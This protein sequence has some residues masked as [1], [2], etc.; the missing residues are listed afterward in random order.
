MGIRVRVLQA[1]HGDSILV[2]HDGPDETFNLLIDGGNGGAFRYGPQERIKGDL[3]KVLDELKA[4]NQHLDLVILTHIDD[5][6]IGGFLRAFKAPGYGEMIKSIWFNTSKLITDHFNSPEIPEND[7]YL[8][9]GS[10]NTS[11]RQGKKFDQLLKDLDIDRGPL[12]IAG[13]KIVLGPFTF[14]ILSPTEKQ[15]QKL[16]CVWPEEKSS[17]DTSADETDYSISFEK[18][19]AEDNF[20]SDTSIA[21]GSSI[22]FMLEAN[23]HA[24]LFLGDAH[25]A[26]VLDGL[27][28]LQFDEAN[29]LQLSLLKVSHHGSEYNTS[30]D[31]LKI[32]SAD[33]YVIS[34]NGSKHGLPNKRTVARILA[35]GDGLICFNYP[36]IAE[37]ILLPK[38][39]IDYAKRFEVISQI[40]FDYDV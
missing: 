21:N 30:M 29:K 31:F 1:N 12:I 10:P 6:H 4:K 2:S 7:I 27:R 38:E 15:L 20:V 14:T 9:D 3:C 25:D 17:P 22:A 5:D 19:W 11:V 13:Q 35:A 37:S 36:K 40:E 32:V 16:L 18:L 28:R 24:M 39:R 8:A 33:R 26:S 23:G 34:T